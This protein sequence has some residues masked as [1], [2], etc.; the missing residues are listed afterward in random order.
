M[1]VKDYRLKM[2]SQNNEVLVVKLYVHK[3]HHMI[4][5]FY[6]NGTYIRYENEV[7]LDDIDEE[8]PEWKFPNHPLYKFIWYKEAYESDDSYSRFFDADNLN[9]DLFAILK[10]WQEWCNIDNILLSANSETK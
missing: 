6:V 7:L 8:R 3:D 5:K 1:P 9:K 4:F 2:M 10:E